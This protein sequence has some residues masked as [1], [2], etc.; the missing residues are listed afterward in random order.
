M[1][2]DE[3][4]SAIAAKT[5]TTKR[6]A[7]EML[8]AVLDTIRDAV[9]DGDRVTLLGFG[10]FILRERNERIGRNPKTGSEITI[11]RRKMPKFVPSKEFKH[12]VE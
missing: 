5:G 8:K 6:S 12:L 1:N 7:E 4:V 11:P 9:R 2:K 10:S 3:L